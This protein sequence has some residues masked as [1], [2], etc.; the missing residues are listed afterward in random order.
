VAKRIG[1]LNLIL[2]I[3]TLAEEAFF[4]QHKNSMTKVVAMAE[5][6]IRENEFVSASK[7]ISE[8]IKFN[9]LHNIQ[10]QWI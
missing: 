5:G 2:I 6:L 3:Y 8:C 1:W 7:G 4:R 9:A 10:R